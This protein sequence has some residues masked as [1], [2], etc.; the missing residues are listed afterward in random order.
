MKKFL[1]LCILVLAGLQ[2]FAQNKHDKKFYLIDI[3]PGFTFEA[4]DKHD[5]DSIL[6]LYHATSNDT[7]RLF[8]LRMFSEGLSNEYLWTR[9]NRYLLNLTESRKDSLGLFY[10]GCALNNVGYEMQYIGNDLT[11]ARQ[12]YRES[13]DIFKKLKHSSGLG[14]E[15]N[16][17]AYIY[18]HEG[19]ISKSLELYLE[20]A[21]LFEK[22]NQPLGLTGIYINLGDICFK[23]DELGKAEEYFRKALKYALMGDQRPVLANVYNQLGTISNRNKKY[24]EALSFYQKALDLYTIERLS[25]KQAL[26]SLG[27]SNVMKNM[28]NAAGSDDYVLK[29]LEFARLSAD[30]QIRAKVYDRYATLLI[31]RGNYAQAGIYAD[32]AYIFAKKLGYTDLLADAAEDLSVVYGRQ[33]DFRKAYGFLKE[34]KALGDSLHND[35]TKK[36]VIRSQYQVEYNKKAVEMKAEEDKKDALRAVERRQQ[37][38]VLALS[39][40]ALTV[41]AVF[42]FLAYRS[43]RKTL[44]QNIVIAEQKNEVLRQNAEISLQ[45]AIV[46]EKKNE[47][48]D[49]I[50]YAR[51]IQQ[52]VLTG[53]E[54][55]KRISGDYFIFYRPKDI[56]SGDFYWAH[57]ISADL[58]VFALA[59]CTGH[60]VPGAFMSMLGNSFLNEIVVENKIYEP[61]QILDRL[62]SKIIAALEQKGQ[63][64]QKDGMDISI[65]LLDKKSMS[66]KW[67]GANN[68]LWI[69]S[70][71][72]MLELKPDTMPVGLYAGPQE[73]FTTLEMKLS[74]GDI[75][76][77]LTDGYADQFGGPHEKKFKYK[78]LKE[79]L[80]S[81]RSLVASRQ[82]EI[83]ESTLDNWKKGFEQVDDI[84]LIGVRV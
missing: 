65:C 84:S 83:L 53:S 30:Q 51:R 13:Y 57:I 52:A 70:E 37:Q 1:A 50:T 64:E 67:A 76:Y 25:G 71:N 75:I 27:L 60:G 69:S 77:L 68:P 5:V 4:S 78:P 12:K 7:L 33:N 59:D 47:M 2:L 79:L 3:D 6:R 14:V 80:Q 20:A 82:K 56:V 44:R 34:S 11:G 62:R 43:Y 10:K 66:L 55:W 31:S 35:E 28:G 74:H 54:V 61:G 8:Y 49:S 29:A 72:E 21:A 81:N 16:N 48:V 63:T 45:K 15:I 40:T 18:Q 36:A 41:I 26:V 42:A 32:S 39:L 73:P 58:S 19:N 23:E 24:Q 17:L 46:E 9:Y 38:L 22:M